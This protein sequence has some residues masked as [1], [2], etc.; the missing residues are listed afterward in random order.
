M[1]VPLSYNLR[2]ILVR[3]SVSLLTIVG[4]AATVAIVAAVIALQEGFANLYTQAGRDDLI[5]LMRPG[6]TYEGDSIFTLERAERLIKTLPEIETNAQGEPLASMEC[7]LAIRRFKAGGGETNVPIRGVQS[8]TLELR[9]D[10]IQIVEGRSFQ[11]GSDEIIVGR[12]LVERI[13]DCRLNDVF[14]LNLT[15]FRVVGVFETAG[16]SSS[17][18]WGDYDRISTALERFGPNR[19]L[20]KVKAGVVVSNPKPSLDPATGK[21]IAREDPNSL[22]GRLEEHIEV[23]A[24]VLTERK[25]LSSLTAALSGVLLGVSAV[26]GTIMGIAAIFAATNTMLSALA[27]RTHEIGILL[28][29]G[30]RPLAIFLSFLFEAVVLGFLGG[31]LGCLLILP[32]SGIETGTTNFQ[33]FT[34]VAFAFRITPRVLLVAIAFSV[35]LGL[36]GGALPAWKA[37]RMT[38]TE[39]LRRV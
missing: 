34:E 2:S 4:V 23:P 31:I 6:A 21:K 22:A 36:A 30:F 3:R 5:C 24:K 9:G 32:I 1:L 12:R 11:P 18:I 28:A 37:S 33:T 13:R 29:A 16:P 8:K 38:P 25:Y 39:A 10:E 14:Q 26:L 17:E 19:I 35:L 27:S 20:A 7:Y 15:P